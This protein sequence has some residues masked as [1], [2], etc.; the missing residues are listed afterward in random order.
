MLWM[1]ERREYKSGQL[2]LIIILRKRHTIG[3]DQSYS[4]ST[5]YP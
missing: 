1:E 4:I 3:H 5:R 2:M